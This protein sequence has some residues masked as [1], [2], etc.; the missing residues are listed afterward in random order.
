[1]SLKRFVYTAVLALFGGSLASKAKADCNCLENMAHQLISQV[2]QLQRE[3][4]TNFRGAR[5]YVRG[6]DDLREIAIL[7]AH[8]DE[9]VH[10]NDARQNL[11][12]DVERL[13]RAFHRFESAVVEMERGQRYGRFGYDS[14][15][16]RTL[17]ANVG[18]T[19]HQLRDL[20]LHG[21]ACG[22][23]RGAT[24][25]LPSTTLPSTTWSTGNGWGTSIPWGTSGNASG[26]Y[27]AP[28]T[29]PYVPMAPQTTTYRNPT[30]P[31]YGG[32][33]PQRLPQRTSSTAGIFFRL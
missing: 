9:S 21:C 13:D 8:I 29:T 19:I 15:V 24:T 17:M 22:T 5:Q 4:A 16:F 20:V 26:G 23:P 27:T 32:Y 28:T 14:P 33:V 25:S 1:M 11:P 7:A 10:Y 12:A 6:L 31:Q 30:V 2:A 18:A 3:Y